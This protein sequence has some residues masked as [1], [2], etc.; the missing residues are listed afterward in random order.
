MVILLQISKITFEKSENIEKTH[1]SQN[2]AKTLTE[3]FSFFKK[4][5]FHGFL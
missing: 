5:L 3:N 4:M 2:L 1:I